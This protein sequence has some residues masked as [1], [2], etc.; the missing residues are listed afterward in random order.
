MAQATESEHPSRMTNLVVSILEGP[1]YKVSLGIFH[2]QLEYF[3]CSSAGKGK[4]FWEYSVHN[5]WTC[6]CCHNVRKYGTEESS[7]MTK[8]IKYGKS[9]FTVQTNYTTYVKHTYY[10]DPSR[11]T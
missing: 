1:L 8:G 10:F 11:T 4:H 3:C 7:N 2:W 6:N 5:A 9:P